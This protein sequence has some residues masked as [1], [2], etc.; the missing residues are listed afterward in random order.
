LLEELH[1]SI[2]IYYEAQKLGPSK[3]IGHKIK[4]CYKAR[5][6]TSTVTQLLQVL[7]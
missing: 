6:E 2:L 4:Y 7:R 1:I 5:L 3:N